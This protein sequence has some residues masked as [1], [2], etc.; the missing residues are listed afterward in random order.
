MTGAM[1]QRRLVNL[2]AG[3]SW[4]STWQQFRP[5]GEPPPERAPAPARRG[6][7]KADAPLGELVNFIAS[8]GVSPCPQ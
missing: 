7:S 1:S 6:P 3:L 5:E 2:I 4:S 8:Q